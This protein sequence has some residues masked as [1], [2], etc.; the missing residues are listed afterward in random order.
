MIKFQRP[1][2]KVVKGKILT[3]IA[4]RKEI[5]QKIVTLIHQNK[6]KDR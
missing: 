6:M 1:K 2:L 4:K 3:K 5:A